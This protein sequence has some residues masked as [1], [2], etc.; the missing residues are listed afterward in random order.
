MPD[1]KRVL[2]V[3]DE[4]RI[5]DGL[6][7]MLRSMRHEWRMSFAESGQE[8][9]AILANE[10][11]DVIVVDMRMP[12]MDG[13]QL[14]SEVRK[15]HQ[16]V[17]IV[18]SGTA[19]K[20]AILRAVGL[21]HQYLSKPCD[22]ETLKSVLA[23]AG[24]LRGLLAADAEAT[25]SHPN[26]ELGRLICQMES[27]PS[28]PSLHKELVE[29][30]GS[31]E[32]S[33]EAVGQIVSRDMGMTARVL[34]LVNSTFFGPR[35]HVAGPAQ[36]VTLLGL[37]T[38]K[39]LDTRVFS[40]FDQ[41]NVESLSLRPL[42]EHSAAV[43]ALARRIAVAENAG[44][45]STDYA[46]MA[47]LLH[48]VGKSVLAAHL[49]VEYGA[50]LALAARK[51]VASPEAERAV[52]GATHAQVGAYLLGL[53]GLPD[54]IVM[55]AALHHDPIDGQFNVL[56]AVQAADFLWHQACPTSR[57]NVSAQLDD[58]YL[59]RP[60]LAERLAVWREICQEAT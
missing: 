24:A 54:P 39:A 38:V 25:N 19:H 48:D 47:G 21:A 32:P 33:T 50:A 45:E 56:T 13:A 10:S 49:P 9:L 15:R 60:G 40:P 36:A 22:A 43:G 3:D 46:L 34:Q 17:R 12:G 41:A 53:W 23:R 5:L 42:W 59:A 44:Q 31:P 30:L 1:K 29:E 16:I 26:D 7:R 55:A 4:P 27:L 20:K 52:F 51:G 11:F 35:H 57:E 8:A 14:L 18:L 28:L 58:T 6:R 37:E 2:F